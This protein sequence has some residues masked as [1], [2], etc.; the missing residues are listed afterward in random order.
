METIVAAPTVVETLGLAR[1]KIRTLKPRC[2]TT[3]FTKKGRQ[4]PRQSRKN[5]RESRELR[6]TP[7]SEIGKKRKQV[8][9][10]A[11]YLEKHLRRR[12]L[13]TK[14]MKARRTLVMEQATGLAVVW[15]SKC[16]QA[17]KSVIL[18]DMITDRPMND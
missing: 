11:G 1:R 3:N 6:E 14:V 2:G 5:S 4:K 15:H 10:K 9:A 8:Q 17:A 16:V 18:T 7:Q 13:P 12:L